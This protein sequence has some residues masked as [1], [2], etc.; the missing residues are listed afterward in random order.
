MT[1]T[2]RAFARNLAAAPLAAAALPKTGLARA[3]APKVPPPLARI[4]L[5][6]FTV[7]FLTDGHFDMPY[8][9]FTGQPP[10]TVEATAK[11]LHADRNG[12][13]RL[14]FTQYLI[15]DGERLVLVD[16]GPAGGIGEHTGLMP[17]ALAAIGVAPEDIDAVILTH[18][19]FDHISGL[20]AGGRAVYPQAE[21]YIDRRDIAHFTDPAKKA[22][23]PD[24]LHSS[25]TAAEALVRLYPR[26]QQIQGAH[27]LLPG[28]ST[29]DLTGHTPGQLGVR[30]ADAGENLLISSDVMFH[31]VVHPASAEAG[32]VFEQDPAAALAMR[33]KFF[34]KAAAEGSLIAATHMPFPGLG[35]IVRDRGALRWAPAEWAHGV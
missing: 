19:H 25:F 34:P 8:G 10:E 23:A 15:D 35:R 12:T 20:I 26:L 22:A 6:R 21:V 13:L 29:V 5:G 30:V 2:R 24:F 31:P 11:A 16:S 27:D 33:R 17:A 28:I 1:L 14:S 3:I 4:A 7:T 18:A 9:F 32:F